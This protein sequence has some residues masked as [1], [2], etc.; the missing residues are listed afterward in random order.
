MVKLKEFSLAL[1]VINNILILN[2]ENRIIF[3]GDE[4]R[5]QLFKS[6]LDGEY[7]ESLPD[8]F[9]DPMDRSEL[10]SK[11]EDVRQNRNTCYFKF[12]NSKT[13][14]FIF[15]ANY[16]QSNNIILAAEEQIL[17]ANNIEFELTERVKELECMY[18]ISNELEATRNLY[19]ALRNAAKHLSK[20]FQYP[21]LI[22][23]DIYL[24]GI[25]YGDPQCCSDNYK[26]ILV[27]PL[28]INDNIR[29]NISVCYKMKEQFLEEEV[30][31]LREIAVMLSNA[32]EKEETSEDLQAQ[33]DLLV[34][35][36]A[37]LTDLTEDLTR[38]NNNLQALLNA[39]TDPLVVIDSEFNI[40]LSNKPEIRIDE[41]CHY[42]LFKSEEVCEN[43]PA[44]V[45]FS[46]GRPFSIQKKHDNLQYNLQA[47]P[48]LNG[49]SE[50]PET[51]L[52]ICSD[53]TED[54]H[55]K[56][57]LFQ[58]YKL[59][60]LGKLVAGVA[61]EIN[62]P[63]TFIR[64]N[65]KII[66]EAF[67]D[68]LPL[69]DHEYEHNKTLKIARLNYELFR[70]H[71]PVLLED[72]MGG[73]N[74][75]KKI[76]DGLRN[77]AK[78][79]E[80]LLTDEVDI[81][82]LIQNNLRITE[83]EVR[84]HAKMVLNLDPTLP[85]FKGNS[86]KIEQVLMNLLINAAQA[87][88]KEDGLIIIETGLDENKKCV[89]IKVNDNGKGMDENTRKHI[90][91]PFFTTKR[92]KGGTGLGLSITYGIITEH[93]GKIM[94]DSQPGVGT[95]FTISIPTSQSSQNQEK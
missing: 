93:S 16:G 54:E 81:N 66:D 23:A 52:E 35:K 82:H 2:Q 51:I 91:D 5:K 29:G 73:A 78:K 71:V 88:E 1:G 8:N 9:L 17:K 92:D 77:F 69:L 33:Q 58:S 31:L 53:V 15:P 14:L 79:D 13:N 39:I 36:N 56:N 67:R 24:D 57:Q 38:T 37:E 43:C 94:V 3:I 62:N 10:V 95:T 41:K 12:K 7:K 68:I 21:Q 30:K 75:I 90:F 20:G 85:T 28:I 60:S 49:K 74:R 61:H 19:D 22:V 34:S 47:Y 65:I 44:I 64:G 26:D 86:Q 46:E 80:G 18:S 45:A 84:K 63:N 40:T 25:S 55:I 4:I 48:I 42:E 50:N 83:K 70:E 89:I 11:I 27:E 76:V 87:I 72:M 32:I 59:A 6:G